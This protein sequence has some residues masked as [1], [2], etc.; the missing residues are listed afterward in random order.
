M[1]AESETEVPITRTVQMDE[2]S[3]GHPSVVHV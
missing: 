2:W 1:Y 3:Y